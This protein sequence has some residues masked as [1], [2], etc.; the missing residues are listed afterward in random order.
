VY[1]SLTLFYVVIVLIGPT[2]AS[3]KSVLLIASKSCTCENLL[4]IIQFS[5]SVNADNVLS[6]AI[7]FTSSGKLQGALL[8]LQPVMHQLTG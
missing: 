8:L 7:V 2:L 1:T 3:L 6:F 5:L 4:T